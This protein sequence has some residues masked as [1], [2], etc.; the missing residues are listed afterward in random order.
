MV[1]PVHIILPKKNVPKLKLKWWAK[2]FSSIFLVIGV[3]FLIL[4][5]FNLSG[6]KQFF[7]LLTSFFCVLFLILI[8]CFF[9]RVYFYGITLSNYEAYGIES[10]TL[11]RKWTAWASENL[12]VIDYCFFTPNKLS[13]SDV[14]NENPTAIYK[15]QALKFT[16]KIGVEYTEEQFFRELLSSVRMTIKT[17]ASKS[18]FEVIL[19]QENN[20]MSY[21]VFKQAWTA[22]GLPEDKLTSYQFVRGKFSIILNKCID[23]QENNKVF[24]IISINI[25][26]VVYSREPCSEFSSI[27]IISNNSSFESESHRCIAFRPTFCDEDELAEEIIKIG[28]YQPAVFEITKV[29]CSGMDTE[30]ISLITNKLKKISPLSSNDWLFSIRDLNMT[31]GRLGRDHSWLSFAFSLYASEV[32]SSGQLMVSKDDE[33]YIFNVIRPYKNGEYEEAKA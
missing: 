32:T 1:W 33:G 17:L 12:Y 27:I 21:P 25:P 19:V 6:N 2:C 26:T 10:D 30:N 16:E 18:E 8:I 24:I 7:T 14:V 4:K 20:S 13:L 5:V 22:T 31:F 29:W 11:I 3:V 15:D 9:V 23:N 28:T